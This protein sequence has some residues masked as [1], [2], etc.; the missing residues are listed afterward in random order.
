MSIAGCGK[1]GIFDSGVSLLLSAMVE[2]CNT[3][4][5]SVSSDAKLT[6]VAPRKLGGLLVGLGGLA[7]DIRLDK[8]VPAK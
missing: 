6:A 3:G 4:L 7:D 5:S 8:F 2:L 1:A